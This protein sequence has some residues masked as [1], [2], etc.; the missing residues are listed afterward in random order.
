MEREHRILLFAIVSLIIIFFIG[1]N[2]L[3]G[4]LVKNNNIF[5][6]INVSPEAVSHEEI[7]YI[8]VIPGSFGSNGRI[9][10][11]KAEDN[12]RKI[13]LD[14]FCGNYKCL[15]ESTISFTVH[16]NWES[17]VYLVKVYDYAKK[18]FI[19]ADFTLSN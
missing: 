9:S 19:I 2:N 13:S 6:S 16:N 14:N 7:I 1:A 11:Y 10:I 12:L 4:K 18:D 5:T 17:G 3:T 15:T 8:N